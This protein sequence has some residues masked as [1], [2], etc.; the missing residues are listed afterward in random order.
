MPTRSIIIRQ[1]WPYRSI[2]LID[3]AVENRVE[4]A[5]ENHDGT[6]TFNVDDG[7]FNMFLTKAIEDATHM[8]L[9]GASFQ[10]IFKKY[11]N[12]IST[13]ILNGSANP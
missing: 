10:A 12:N 13:W 6:I 8:W 1:S 7:D 2:Q 5:H 11:P 4:W 3:T 9:H